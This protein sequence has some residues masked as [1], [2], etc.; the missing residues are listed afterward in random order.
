M[1]DE[2]YAMDKVLEQPYVSGLLLA[3]IYIVIFQS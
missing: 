3:R 1:E 2:F